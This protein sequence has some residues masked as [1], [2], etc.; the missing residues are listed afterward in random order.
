MGREAPRAHRE[1]DMVVVTTKRQSNGEHWLYV[2]G[3]KIGRAWNRARF[4][5]CKSDSFGLQLR[6]IYWL[7]NGSVMEPNPKSGVSATTTKT[8]REAVTLAAK[9]W[10]D[11]MA[12]HGGKREGAG[13]KTE[14]GAKVEVQFLMMVT[15]AQREKIRAG[16]GAPWVRGLIDKE[17]LTQTASTPVKSNSR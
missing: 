11:K 16:G 4:F 3:I 15:V 8:L 1:P 5:E 14:D 10:G 13:R 17:P 2:D 12:G 6:G 7:R 9:V